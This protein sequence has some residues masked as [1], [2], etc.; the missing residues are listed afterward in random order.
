[1]GRGAKACLSGRAWVY[2]LAW[3]GGKGVEKAL[4]IG[5]E[6]RECM[7]FSG[8]TDIN[9]IPEATVTAQPEF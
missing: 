6:L 9:R 5:G 2:G 1:M 4:D 3:D 8:F 7:S